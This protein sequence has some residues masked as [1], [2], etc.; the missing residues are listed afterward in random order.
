M[1]LASSKRRALSTVVT[2]A[3]MLSFVATI[4]T[5]VVAWSNTNVRT[6]EFNLVSSAADKT[7]KINEMYI[8][9]NV[10][11]RP[12]GNPTCLVPPNYAINVTVANT[13][14]VS[15]GVGQITIS[16]SSQ[17]Y[18]KHISNGQVLPH[19]SYFNIV[20]YNYQSGLLTTIQVM[21]NRTTQQTAQ[22]VPP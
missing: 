1:V 19:R 12:A 15:L 20:C 18:V 14:T 4:G 9:E 10:E 16:D 2:T 13:G 21:S 7:N 5:A 8:I 3:I 17:Q 6:Y 22:V 11:L